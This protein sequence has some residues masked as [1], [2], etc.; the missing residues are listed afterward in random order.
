MV[1]VVGMDGGI[2]AGCS[3]GFRLVLELPCLRSDPVVAC[4]LA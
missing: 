2:L 3:A 1:V 4:L